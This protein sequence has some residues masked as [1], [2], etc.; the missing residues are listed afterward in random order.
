[1]IVLVSG[2]A[3]AGKT[4][5]CNYL[6]DLISLS[7]PIRTGS[8]KSFAKSLK[9]QAKM[10][11]WD[12]EKDS[13]GRKFLQDLGAV[14]REYNKDVWV[15]AAMAQIHAADEDFTFIDD[16]RFPNE[17][18]YMSKQEF[19]NVV[20]TVRVERPEQFHRLL[21]KDTYNDISEVALPELLPKMDPDGR[22]DVITNPSIT[23][24]YD[25]VVWNSGSLEDLSRSAHHIVDELM[26]MEA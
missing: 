7:D 13:K 2:R 26:T 22:A 21:G 6:A 15:R 23:G 12:G 19:N 18:V 5:L 1:M 4:V 8:V 24:Q 17:L 11:M 25:L 14:A 9:D 3:G 10:M 16:W 20:V